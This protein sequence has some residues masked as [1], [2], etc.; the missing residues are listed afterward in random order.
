MVDQSPQVTRA[1]RV[2]HV[3]EEP[4]AQ[5]IAAVYATAMLDAQGEQDGGQRIA[6][7]GEFIT[8]ILD[9]NPG[10]ETVLSSPRVPHAEKLSLLEKTIFPHASQF[11]VNF[12]K[13]LAARGRLDLIRAIHLVA[14][15]DLEKRLGQ[16]KVQV[17]TALELSETQLDQI[18][19]A[20]REKLS[21]EP[22]LHV[23]TDPNL[24]GG[25]VIQ[26]GDTVYDSSLRNRLGQLQSRL[27]QRYVHE[28]Q[29]GRDRFSHSEGS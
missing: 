27:R 8:D 13:V 10:F 17:R 22:V 28:I 21:A 4:G 25:L 3:F 26:V 2:P 24:I 18:R 15:T 9:A 11:F 16:R 23:E 12:L 1:A 6:E 19:Q 29:S 5:S 7:L 14:T 20:L